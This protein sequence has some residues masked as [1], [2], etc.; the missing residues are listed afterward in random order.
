MLLLTNVKTLIYSLSMMVTLYPML[1]VSETNQY[2]A[3]EN[4][5]DEYIILT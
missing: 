2:L 3:K 1:E 4:R 5:S